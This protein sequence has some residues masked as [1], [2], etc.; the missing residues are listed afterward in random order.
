MAH[1]VTQSC[2]NDASCVAVCPVDCIHPTPEERAY[3]STE[4]LFIDPA[5]CIDCGACVDE[6]PVDAIVPPEDLTAA[7]EPYVALNA[8][9]YQDASKNEPAPAEIREEVTVG[10]SLGALR[11]AIVGAGP[12]ACYLAEELTA[13]PG[14]DVEVTILERLP[15]PGGLVRYG[16]APDH[17]RTKL[18][19]SAF[20]RTLG[21]KNCSVHLNVTVGEHLSHAEVLEH[22]HAVV[23]AT[24]ASGDRTLDIPGVDLA[25]NISA[26]E[27]S[28]WYN[29]HPDEADR[30]FDLSGDRAV[31]I[32]N[33]NVALDIARI[34]V[35]DVSRLVGTDIANHALELLASSRIRE[36]TILGRRGADDAAFSTP[37][38]LGLSQIPG[39][40]VTAAG[41][42]SDDSGSGALSGIRASTVS[43]YASTVPTSGSRRIHLQFLRTP[44]AISG[45]NAAKSIRIEK[46]SIES[47]NG[48]RAL[49]GTGEFEDI[50]AG[51]IVR[52]IGFQAD[53]IKGLPFDDC[54]RILPNDR[55]AVIEPATGLP[56]PGVYT[57][58]WLK[59]GPS[60]VIGSNRP[61]SRETANQI[62]SDF[63]A[64]KLPKPRESSNAFD[65][66]VRTRQPHQVDLKG[67]KK[68]D[69]QERKQGKAI[70]RPRVKFV[71]KDSMVNVA[72]GHARD[73]ALDAAAGRTC[74][75]QNSKNS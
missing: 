54:L 17:S 69:A 46:N 18:I 75:S 13:I 49:V 23:Y 71:E 59:R 27:F 15:V 45:E 37:E 14:L 9:Y 32:G 34:L 73:D 67:W 47:V 22:H 48:Q 35:S 16:V 50:E 28:A 62:V 4:M 24:G 68:I 21:R 7:T 6:C 41:L 44:I 70:G 38:L 31:I 53:R 25:G 30:R 61:C 1:V 2:C 12:S 51:L 8:A 29:G 43:R 39:V 66:L 56:V 57:V 42:G 63:V 58:G 74:G 20:T 26:R 10:N 65:D 55:G 52:S 3:V 19:S 5:T 64:G 36:V 40:E 11:V 60:G 33:G 72:L